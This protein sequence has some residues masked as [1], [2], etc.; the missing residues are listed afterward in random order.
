MRLVQSEVDA[1][2]KGW[3]LGDGIGLFGVGSHVGSAA[4]GSKRAV[5]QEQSLELNATSSGQ[6]AGSGAASARQPLFG[7]GANSSSAATAADAGRGS[8]PSKAAAVRDK[9][10]G[11]TSGG[12]AS[13]AAAASPEQRPPQQQWQAQADDQ[14]VDALFAGVEARPARQGQSGRLLDQPADS[15]SSSYALP[16]KRGR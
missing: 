9:Y 8:P 15:S 7:G 5:A 16:W 6:A 3:P 12:V 4:A 1:I 14:S 2:S 13:T 10:S 11:R